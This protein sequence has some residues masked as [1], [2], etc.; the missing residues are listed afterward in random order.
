MREAEIRDVVG[1][2]VCELPIRERPVVLERVAPPGADMHLVDRYRLLQWVP[3]PPAV[4]PFLVT[5]AMLSLPDDRR[6][7]RRHLGVERDRIGLQPQPDVPRPD[8]ELVLR[9]LVLG[10]YEELPD[11]RGAERAHRVQA[12][13]PRVEVADDRDRPRVWRPDR[14]RGADD[15]LDLAH[16][17]AEQLV[18][19]L[20]AALERQVEVQL[21]ERGEERGR[22]PGG[23]TV[24]GRGVDP[25][26]G[27]G[28]RPA[29]S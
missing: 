18:Q 1:E 20:V 14:E 11:P 6:V 10:W 21:A 17:G 23:G 12:P 25:R 9:P 22:I 29:P 2:L 24:C 15:A 13:V 4:E 7:R 28:R 26:V 19:V 27:A 16:V 8:L 3:P 5:P